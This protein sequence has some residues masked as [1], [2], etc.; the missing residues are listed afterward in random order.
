[1]RSVTESTTSTLTLA[2]LAWDGQCC[3]AKHTE[4]AFTILCIIKHIQL[5]KR[6]METSSKKEEH[7]AV[8]IKGEE[9]VPCALCNQQ[10][11]AELVY[12][13]LLSNKSQ[14]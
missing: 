12:I 14:M 8:Q 13:K 9:K 4:A 3:L 10:L 2:S 11:N 5:P 7:K 1:M 6:D